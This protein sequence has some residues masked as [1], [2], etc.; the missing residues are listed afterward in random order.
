M[1]KSSIW[2]VLA[3]ILEFGTHFT[4]G[5]KSPVISG[6]FFPILTSDGDAVSV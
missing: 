4:D 1:E 5:F 3:S 6:T 2:R